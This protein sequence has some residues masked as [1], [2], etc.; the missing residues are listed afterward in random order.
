MR[1]IGVV[2]F[3]GIG[4][5]PLA[6]RML[7]DMGAEVTAIVRPRAGAVEARLGGGQDNPLRLGKR[8]V[9]LDLKTSEGVTRAL[10]L[11][12][13]ADALIEGNRPGAMERLGLGPADCAARNP[14]LVYGRMTGWGQ[15]GPLAQAAGHDLN[16]VALTG[17]LSLA[18][19]KG[20]APMVPP[21][22]V[23]DAGGALGL[24]F[25][26][27]CALLD[28]RATGRG[29]VVDAAIVDVVAMLGTIA[30]WI[31]GS[32]QLD[33]GQPSPFHDS[34]FY[35][36]YECSDGGFVTVGALEPQFY[37]QLL[38]RLGL[39]D[40]DP[41]AQ[42]DRAAW[43]ALKARVAALFRS[44]PRAAWC[45]LLEGTD[46]C[47]APVLSLAEAASHPH[48]LARGIYA[49]SP[50]GALQSAGAPRFL[51]LVR[52]HTDKER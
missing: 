36:V 25:G 35:D 4:P 27:A 23:G 24:A 16:Y 46:A 1:G 12:G 5:G 47:F 14:R 13:G 22:V 41:A 2:E 26:V 7:A 30:Q 20:E 21:T 49:T 15:G 52:P 3:E 31:R 48:N 17:L 33:S 44:R 11:V 6:G 38:E 10:E 34:P 32:G 29:R 37:A 28:A 45:A 9:A 19:R 40:V 43:P 18:S 42:Y 8:I 51:P 39:A 50:S